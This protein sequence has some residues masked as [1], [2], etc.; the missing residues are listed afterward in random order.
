MTKVYQLPTQIT[1]TVGVLP[2]QKYAIFGDDLAT[3]TTA[4]YLNQASLEANPVSASDII[5]ALYSYN[6]QTKTGTYGVFTVAIN[7]LGVIT[8]TAW[9]SPGDV[10]LP[11][12]DNDFAV[13]NGTSGQLQDAGYSPTD[14]AKT[15]VVM[16][17]AAPTINHVAIFTSANGTIG[18]GGVLGTAAAKAAS[19][20]TKAT[21]ASVNAATTANNFAMFTDNAGTVGDI[22]KADGIEA[23]NAVTAS[24]KAGV[25]TTSALTTAAGASYAITWTN[26]QIAAASSIQLTL[27]GGTNTVKSITL[28]ATA[29]AGTSTL[30]IYNVG[31]TDPLDG[32]LLIGYVVV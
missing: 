16:L 15:K 5:Q 20:N 25:I 17:N 18:D 4:G 14:P 31:P 6:L 19:D 23:A 13:F 10:V 21:V 26:T 24:G 2:T 22:L 7:N 32:T 12:V 3:V 8:L 9:S 29:G 28:E 11:V 30:T 27:M 1:G